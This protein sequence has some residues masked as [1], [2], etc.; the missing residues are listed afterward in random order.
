MQRRERRRSVS[1]VFWLDWRRSPR[2]WCSC[3]CS[4]TP[5]CIC[6]RRAR[7]RCGLDTYRTPHGFRYILFASGRC[8]CLARH[9]TGW[10]AGQPDAAAGLNSTPLAEMPPDHSERNNR[11]AGDFPEVS[12]LFGRH[13][14]RFMHSSMRCTAFSDRTCAWARNYEGPPD[15]R[16]PVDGPSPHIDRLTAGH[17]GV[18]PRDSGADRPGCQG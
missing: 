14:H 6:W 11:Q 12:Q 15:R 1:S 7:H 10:R 18:R 3:F 17:A 4:C 2:T 5:L 9:F 13:S 16:L 8:L